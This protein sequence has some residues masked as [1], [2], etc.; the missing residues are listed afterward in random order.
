METKQINITTP[1]LDLFDS[2]A[3]LLNL[4]DEQIKHYK[5]NYLRTWEGDH[6][7]NQSDNKM[8]IALLEAQKTELI[9]FFSKCDSKSQTADLSI[10]INLDVSGKNEEVSSTNHKI[11]EYA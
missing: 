7:T 6:A 8:K 3:M 1:S 10:G 5:L 4:I 9:E 2:K 11:L